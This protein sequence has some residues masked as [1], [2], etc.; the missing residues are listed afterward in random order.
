MGGRGSVG[1]GEPEAGP[2]STCPRALCVRACEATP[3]LPAR[4]GCELAAPC[5]VPVPHG[6]G[7]WSQ[8]K[9]EGALG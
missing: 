2:A 7:W 3:V 6:A 8:G 4:S 1:V 5:L 9:P